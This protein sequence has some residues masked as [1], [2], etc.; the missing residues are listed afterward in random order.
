MHRA[1]EVQHSPH[2]SADCYSDLNWGWFWPEAVNTLRC[3]N[4]EVAVGQ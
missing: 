2:S 4:F 3:L 1:L